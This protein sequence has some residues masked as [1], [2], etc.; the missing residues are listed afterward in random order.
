MEIESYRFGHMRLDGKD[1]DHDLIVLQ[2]RIITP[3]WRSER[4][5][6]CME[7]LKDVISNK[8][9]ILIIGTGAYGV[10]K[11]PEEIL[12]TI[13]KLN[14]RCLSMITFKAYKLFNE[15]NRERK[16]VVGAFHLTC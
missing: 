6:L 8:P 7:D 10:L 15:Y 12:S 16:N 1:Y 14:I 3:W 11:V 9:E 4:H 13:Q 5:S 2:N